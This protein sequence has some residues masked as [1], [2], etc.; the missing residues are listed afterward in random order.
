MPA[1][2]RKGAVDPTP[3]NS[4]VDPDNEDMYHLPYD[5]RTEQ[6]KRLQS[7]KQQQGG[8]NSSDTYSDPW[9]TRPTSGPQSPGI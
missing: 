5:A 8:M 2:A 1:D 4:T 7:S 6:L 9:D 3:T